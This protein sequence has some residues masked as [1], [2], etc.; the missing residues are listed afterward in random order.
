LIRQQYLELGSRILAQLEQFDR[1]TRE[2]IQD[3][4]VPSSTPQ[5][6]ANLIALAHR[7]KPT[8]DR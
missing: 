2:A 7:L 3:S 1:V 4:Q 5:D 6:E 8:T